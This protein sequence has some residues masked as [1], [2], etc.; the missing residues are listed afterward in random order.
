MPLFLV[1]GRKTKRKIKRKARKRMKKRSAIVAIAP[2]KYFDISK[3]N[4]EKIKEYIRK[5]GKRKADIICFPESCLHKTR[6][7]KVDDIL[8]KEIREECRKNNIWCIIT[9]D[10]ILKKKPYNIAI[11][12]GRDGE[13][14]GKYKKIHIYDEEVKE[15]KKIRV[16][17]TDFA[18][19]GIVICWDL[20]FPELFKKMKEKGAEIIFCPAQWCYEQKAYDNFHKQR[21]TELLKSLLSARAFENLFFVALVNPLRDE[22]DQVSY[23][24]IVSPHKILKETINKERLMV[25]KINLN[26]IKKYKKIYEKY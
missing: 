18:K 21:E 8:I 12:I 4:L 3:D 20:A 23:S 17:K 16:F 24:A 13:I 2:I 6:V 22:K 25:A 7:F 19:I 1:M 15:G 26:E 5:A 14:K 11:L 10:L 9:E